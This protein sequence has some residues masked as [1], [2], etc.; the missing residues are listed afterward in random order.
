MCVA[1][2]WVTVTVVRNDDCKQA[3]I[4]V[5]K[6]TIWSY[7]RVHSVMTNTW[8]HPRTDWLRINLTFDLPNAQISCKNEG[9]NQ[10][11]KLFYWSLSPRWRWNDWDNWSPADNVCSWIYLRVRVTSSVTSAPWVMILWFCKLY[12]SLFSSPHVSLSGWCNMIS[13]RLLRWNA[14]H[15]SSA[16]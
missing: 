15:L 8:H 11:G 4:F 9:C 13:E 6:Q 5:S 3:D 10:N 12:E 16:T 7:E 2:S 1:Q 14:S